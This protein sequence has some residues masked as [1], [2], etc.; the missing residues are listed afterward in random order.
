MAK[1]K[2]INIEA[3]DLFDKTITK[4]ANNCKV[5]FNESSI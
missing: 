2:L 4:T 5:Y 1:K 3:E